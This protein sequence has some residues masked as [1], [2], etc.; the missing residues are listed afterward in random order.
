MI[1]YY[2]FWNYIW[3]L[4]YEFKIL[5]YNYALYLSILNTSI[6]GAFITYIYPR[7]M[8]IN[9]KNKKFHLPYYILI[10][11]DLLIHQLPLYR[12]YTI[13][14]N[15]ICGLYSLMPVLCWYSINKYR[16][17]DMDDLYDIKINKIIGSSLI[18]VSSLGIYNHFLKN[19]IINFNHKIY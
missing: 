8:I 19:H 14:Y 7:K 2:S 12:L 13:K 4:G 10:P 6:I 9:V 3:Y 15:S 17:I 11:G 5:N 16:N 1:K 18:F